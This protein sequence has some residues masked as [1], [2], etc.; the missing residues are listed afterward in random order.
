MLI[1]S[2][3]RR[4]KIPPAVK[5]S[6]DP[7]GI[8]LIHTTIG[9]LFSSNKTGARIWHYLEQQM[10]VDAM[11]SEISREYGIA[12]TAGRE[13]VLTFLAE[14]QRHGLIECGS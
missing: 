9:R 5:A 3:A 13:H 2:D 10:S 4:L 8:V 14:L 12:E 6:R 11:A 1:N 7:D